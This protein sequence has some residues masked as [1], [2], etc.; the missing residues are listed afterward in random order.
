MNC[1]CIHV[2]ICRHKQKKIMITSVEQNM[3]TEPKC[4]DKS[5]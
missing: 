5:I 2:H 4:G 3:T 1:G